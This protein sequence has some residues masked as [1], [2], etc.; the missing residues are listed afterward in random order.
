MTEAEII[1]FECKH[2]KKDC[3]IRG[4]TDFYDNP[5]EGQL[6][7]CIHFDLD[8]EEVKNNEMPSIKRGMF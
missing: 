4:M 7:L 6:V 5:L 8:K 3:P 1:C 2:Y